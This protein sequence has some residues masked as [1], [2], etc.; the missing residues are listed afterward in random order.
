MGRSSTQMQSASGEIDGDF[1][2]VA[3]AV[4]VPGFLTGA[5][6]FEPICKALTEKGI[7]TVA[8]PMPNWHWLPSLG[9]R[10]ARPIL[11]RI[12]FTVKHLVANLET[13]D[14]PIL[15]DVNNAVLNIPKYDYSIF[16]CWKDF[17][18]TPGGALKV[19]GASSVDEYPVVEPRGYF[20]LPENLR[21][22][23][24]APKKKIALIGHSAGGW[25]S[26]VY[27]SSSDYGGKAYGGTDYI[28]SLITL[29]TPHTNAGGPA[30][31][32]IRWINDPSKETDRLA[33]VRSLSV[34]GNGFKGDEWGQLTAGAY[35]F[36]CPNGTDGSQ[37][38]GDGV[39]PIFSALGMPG[40]EFLEVDNVTHFCWSDV[41]GGDQVAPE[42][43]ED[44]RSGKAWYGSEEI[45][46]KWACF[47]NEAKWKS[48]SRSEQASIP[49]ETQ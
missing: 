15:S 36:C 20:P 26:R 18:E 35:G 11:E 6:E 25:I 47:I 29:G 19:G 46:E 16:D 44:H 21:A 42:L 5:D 12:D 41:F 38:Y 49:S 3:A 1:E 48:K 43:T 22:S 10:S 39:T 2:H 17:R 31:D 37:Y 40:S 27:L 34:S 23:N 9:G 32:G 4:F 14:N 24:N 33:K 45:L 7:P 13:T 8:V 28:H 30:F